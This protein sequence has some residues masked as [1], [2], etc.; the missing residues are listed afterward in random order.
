[1]IVLDAVTT[2]VS[3]LLLAAVAVGVAGSGI[4]LGLGLA[5]L[6]Q[7]RSWS[8]LLVA[9]AL[10]ALFARTGV[11]ALSLTNA[12]GPF[13]HH[14]LEHALDAVMVALV[15]GAVY[16]ARTVERNLD[17]VEGADGSAHE[18]GGGER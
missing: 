1:M 15:V 11:A 14:L 12:I 2:Q 10:A 4:L 17:A 9:G 5:A 7:R 6:L 3:L 8:Y 13:V 18:M 16:H